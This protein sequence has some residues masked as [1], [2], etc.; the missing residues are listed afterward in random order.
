MRNRLILVSAAAL[1]S[2]SA[3][4]Y[5]QDT[6]IVQE[7]DPVTTES[8]VVIPGEV[9]TYVLEQDIP[10]VPYEGDIL[11]GKVVPD[12]VEIHAI[13]GQPDYA[14]TIVNEHRVIVNPQTRT[15]IQVLE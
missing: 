5:A 3:S 12:A 13:D 7:S 14:Y 15:V 8:T 6:V 9:R 1:L 2:L 10:S 11:I 4:A